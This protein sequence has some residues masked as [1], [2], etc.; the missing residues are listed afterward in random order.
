[1]YD[2]MFADAKWQA[3][4]ARAIQLY[5][6]GCDAGCH[7]GCINLGNAYD[8]GIIVPSSVAAAHEIFR[9]VCESGDGE[10]CRRLGDLELRAGRA[11]AVLPLRR[12]CELGDADG[13]ST[14][15]N[16]LLEST[17]DEERAAGMSVLVAVCTRT[18]ALGAESL[19]QMRASRVSEAACQKW[20][21]LYASKPPP[22]Q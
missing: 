8:K 13:C 11:G 19:S 17:A 20:R 3:D 7:S 16:V 4:G 5:R 6:R 12:A 9:Q 18:H 15:A 10:G 2:P 1:M 14:L 21:E 22:R